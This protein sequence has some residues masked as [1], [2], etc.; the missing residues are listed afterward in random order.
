MLFFLK[1][2][3]IFGHIVVMNNLFNK[4]HLRPNIQL[5]SHRQQKLSVFLESLPGVTISQTVSTQEV[6]LKR[7][8]SMLPIAQKLYDAD[9]K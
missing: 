8:I 7:L 3:D 4:D 1:E 6:T 2:T 9:V 5:L